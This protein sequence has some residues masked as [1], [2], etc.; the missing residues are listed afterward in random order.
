MNFAPLFQLCF[1]YSKSNEFSNHQFILFYLFIYLF[2]YLLT[3]LFILLL[4]AASTAHGCS[5]A[6]GPTRATVAGPHHSHSSVRSKLCLQLHHSLWQ[7]QILNPLS[8]ARDQS[9]NLGVPS[10]IRF[11]CCTIGTPR[12]INFLKNKQTRSSHCGSVETNL[13]SICED[14][15]SIPG[16]VQWVVAVSCGVVHRF[17]LDPTLLW[18]WCGLAAAAPIR[19]H[20]LGEN[21]QTKNLK[22]F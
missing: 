6:R 5:Q 2:I 22:G 10:R 9:H 11:H 8:V 20:R 15:G 16:L 1:G 14:A 21:K 3:Y 17:G 4:R 19:P 13:T 12:I 7:C 18:L